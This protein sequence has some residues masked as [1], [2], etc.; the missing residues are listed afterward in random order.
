[1]FA[2]GGGFAI[3]PPTL[4]SLL[5]VVGG[6]S[7]R[8][9]VIDDHIV[10]RDVLDL[11]VTIDH[12]IVDGAPATREQLSRPVDEDRLGGVLSGVFARSSGEFAAGEGCPG[13]DEGD[14]V[15]CVDGAPAVFA[16]IR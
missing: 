4:A 3:A 2:G 8:A 10:V 9:R 7:E 12:N 13:A 14:E 5:V 16:L 6:F 1:M 11:T 15:G